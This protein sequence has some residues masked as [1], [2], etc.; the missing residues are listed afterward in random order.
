[1]MIEKDNCY[2]SFLL[3]PSLQNGNWLPSEAE[4]IESFELERT[5]KGHLL[6][7][8][9]NEL[10]HLQLDQVAQSPVQPDLECLQG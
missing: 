6:Q 7:L 1:M 8:L 2:L 9:C 5:L 10:G 4:I 3:F